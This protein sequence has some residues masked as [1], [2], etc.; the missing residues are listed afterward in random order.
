[1]THDYTAEAERLKNSETAQLRALLLAWDLVDQAFNYANGIM[2]P[3]RQT[4]E[5][6]KDD[7][8]TNETESEA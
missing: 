4:M 6:T 7:L 2:T 1:M 3:L 8:S 5:G